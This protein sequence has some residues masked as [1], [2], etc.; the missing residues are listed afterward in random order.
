MIIEGQ[1]CTDGQEVY[2]AIKIKEP[3]NALMLANINRSAKWKTVKYV[4]KKGDIVLHP[5]RD[6][7][8]AEG[9]LVS[10]DQL[11][12]GG[13]LLRPYAFDFGYDY[14]AK[15][16]IYTERKTYPSRLPPRKVQDM[17]PCKVKISKV[18]MADWGPSK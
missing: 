9:Y 17:T 3:I 1:T 14:E 15:A 16:V 2:K 10:D 6:A 11:K 8:Y 5:D 12:P 18:S 13:D 7:G 4:T